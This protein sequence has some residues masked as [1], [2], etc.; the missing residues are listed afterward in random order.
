MEEKAVDTPIFGIYI[1]NGGKKGE[2]T[3]GGVNETHLNH[4]GFNMKRNCEARKKIK[5]LFK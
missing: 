3:F 2:I 4:K 5:S 1:P